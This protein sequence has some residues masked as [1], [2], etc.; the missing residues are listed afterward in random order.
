MMAKVKILN[1]KNKW[2]I[3]CPKKKPRNCGALL[4][5]KVLGTLFQC[6]H[7]GFYTLRKV[8]DFEDVFVSL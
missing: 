3:L 6:L 4:S 7:F 8:C 2:R 1:D 5:I